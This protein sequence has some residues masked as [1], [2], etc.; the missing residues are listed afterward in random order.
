MSNTGNILYF[1]PAR[2]G[3]KGLPGKNI[4][5]MNGKPLIA[6]SIGTALAAAAQ[7]GGR[8]VVSTDSEEIADIARKAGAEVPF[9][10]PAEL[11]SDKAPTIDVITHALDHFRKEGIEFHLFCL[12]EATSPQRDVKDITA[13]YDLLLKTK[14]AE[15]VV[16]V[17]RAESSHPAFLVTKDSSG[18]IK[19]YGSDTF[20]VKRRQD[21]GDVYFYEGSLYI[22]YTASLLANRSFY[23]AKTIGYEMPK[24]KSFEVDDIV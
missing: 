22:S 7:T 10:R 12:L 23:H 19:P 14:S 15:S 20:V 2:G 16:G 13:A 5:M 9:L 21:I 4:R 24:W 6:W 8:V 1:I 17:C 11:A 18:F 3:S